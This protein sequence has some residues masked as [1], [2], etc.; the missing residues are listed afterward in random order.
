MGYQ[1]KM[2]KSRSN[3]RGGYHQRGSMPTMQEPDNRFYRRHG[4]FGDL[5][6]RTRMRKA[7]VREKLAANP[8]LVRFRFLH[9]DL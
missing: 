7:E 3:Y 4:K 5:K 9:H 2:H 6:A 1:G 8:R